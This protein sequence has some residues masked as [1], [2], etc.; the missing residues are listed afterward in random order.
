[1][2]LAFDFSANLGL[3]PVADAERLRAHLQAAR[4]PTGLEDVQLEGRAAGIFKAMLADKKAQSAGLTL[5]LTRGIGEAF[6]ARNV[7]L[8]QLSEFLARRD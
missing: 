1:M 2:T 6:V 4:L 5:I 3:C 7:D 8:D